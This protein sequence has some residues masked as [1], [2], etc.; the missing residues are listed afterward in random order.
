MR[1]DFIYFKEIIL[2]DNNKFT[3]DFSDEEF[4]QEIHFLTNRDY[5]VTSL[6]CNLIL[7]EYIND[8]KR[9][10]EELSKKRRLL[11]EKGPAYQND[12]GYLISEISSIFDI[13]NVAPLTYHFT[14][15]PKILYNYCYYYKF[16]DTVRKKLEIAKSILH[17]HILKIMVLNLK[18][19]LVKVKKDTVT[20]RLFDHYAKIQN[21]FT[22]NFDNS[23]LYENDIHR[24]INLMFTY[25]T[26]NKQW[27]GTNP[28][29]LLEG[30]YFA[31]KE[32]GHFN[33]IKFFKQ[34]YRI[35]KKGSGFVGTPEERQ[36]LNC[37]IKGI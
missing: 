15:H 1:P 7:K 5:Y 24:D 32:K 22:H 4:V 20:I 19:S 3:L 21:V 16:Y 11:I 23:W 8:E 12:I 18:G 2:N 37:K 6:N 25:D 27:Y 29:L 14:L 33:A 28:N 35:K 13:K 30:T 9:L 10:V 34:F 31:T 36:K 26:N 17:F